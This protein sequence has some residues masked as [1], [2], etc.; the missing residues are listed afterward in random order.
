MLCAPGFPASIDDADKPFLLNHAMALSKAGIRVTVV[1][2][3][4]NGLPLRHHIDGIEVVRVRYAPRRLQTLAS[5][6]SMYRE[7]RGLKSLLV[8]P[9][10]LSLISTMVLELRRKKAVAYGHWWVPGG[11]VA[12]VAAAIIRRPSIVHLHGS[13]ASITGNKIIRALASF[14]MRQADV[15]IAVSEELAE[16]GVKV[17]SRDCRVIPM[18][19]DLENFAKA[20]PP[21]DDGLTLGVGRLVTEKG[22]DLLIEAVSLIDPQKRPEITIVGVG[23]QRLQ[24]QAQARRLGVQLHLPGAVSPREMGDWYQRARIVVVPSRREGFGLVAAEAAA[25]GRAVV[26][27]SVGGIPN[28]V[29]PGVSGLLVAPADVDALAAALKEVDPEWGV[30]GPQL[31]EGLGGERHGHYLRQVCDDLTR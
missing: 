6:G 12:V 30:N 26:G 11:L 24:L 28:V 20:P 15:C 22:Y 1:C 7:A 31:V 25:A 13:D 18:P 14:V 16:W 2:P 19:V 5:T 21:S 9:M 17:S 23:P 29:R 4:V 27:T 10:L 3:M 8:I